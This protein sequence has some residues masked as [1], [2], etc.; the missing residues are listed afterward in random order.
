MLLRSDAATLEVIERRV[1]R[2]IFCPVSV[3]YPNEKKFSGYAGHI[4]RIA[5]DVPAS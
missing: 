4:V 5:E 2:E 1:L 3:T